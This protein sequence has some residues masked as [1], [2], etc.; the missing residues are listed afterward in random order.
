MRHNQ[1]GG[2]DHLLAK[3]EEVEIERP[4]APAHGSL[5]AES[6]LD[7]PK[8]TEKRTGLDR[9]L[10]RG[11][12]VEERALACWTPHRWC[13]MIGAYFPKV[14][15]WHLPKGGDRTI[16]VRLAVAQVGSQTK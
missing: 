6:S 2:L 7:R 15:A 13:F 4:L 12:G 10:G 9:W 14:H 8:L 3:N 11:H 1:L 16:Q 5:S